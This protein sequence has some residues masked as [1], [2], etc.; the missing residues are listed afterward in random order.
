MAVDEE[1][2]EYTREVTGHDR[3]HNDR[4]YDDDK[5]YDDDRSQHDDQRDNDQRKYS[6]RDDKLDTGQDVR[7]SEGATQNEEATKGSEREVKKIVREGDG[8]GDAAPSLVGTRTV[9]DRTSGREEYQVLFDL[10]EYHN[11]IK[12]QNSYYHSRN[13]QEHSSCSY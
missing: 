5:G 6:E 3:G 12:I 1:A 10:G 9:R 13:F 11:S 4:R 7:G 8:M 2:D